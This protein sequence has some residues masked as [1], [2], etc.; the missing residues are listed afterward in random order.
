MKW[1]VLLPALL[2]VA[3]P[4]GAQALQKCRSHD[5]VTA[6]R[7]GSCVA[8][9]VLVATRD[10][11][12]DPRNAGQPPTPPTDAAR[13]RASTKR[14]SASARTRGRGRR[15]AGTRKDPCTS[16]KVARNEFQ[17]RRGLRITMADLS[18]WNHRVY[19]ACK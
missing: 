7:S 2:C 14:P 19:D 1:T 18:R 8:G 16:A 15:G 10:F 13:E 6:Y 9:E 4:S 17:Q 11:A 12:P 5:G 3:S